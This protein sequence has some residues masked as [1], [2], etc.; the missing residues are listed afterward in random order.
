MGGGCSGAGVLGSL[1]R[2]SYVCLNLY[3]THPLPVTLLVARTSPPPWTGSSR[4]DS[5]ACMCP[6]P[7]VCV[8]SPTLSAP[9]NPPVDFYRNPFGFWSQAELGTLPAS[10]GP[11]RFKVWVQPYRRFR[12]QQGGSPHFIS[13]EPLL[14]GAPDEAGRLEA[15]SQSFL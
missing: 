10:L 1:L 14:P 5:L 13:E 7:S 8:P 2:Q 15:L 11:L 12:G 9:P 6:H 3:H 4:R